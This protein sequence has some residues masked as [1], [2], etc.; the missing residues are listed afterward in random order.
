M[1]IG[2]IWDTYDLL[3]NAAFYAGKD[4]GYYDLLRPPVMSILTSFYF[5]DGLSVWPI[6]FIDGV[7]FVLGS[8]GLYLFFRLSFDDLTS[9]LGALLFVTFPIVLTFATAGLTDLSS[10]C[11]SIWGLLFTVLAV[12]KNTRFFYLAF[13]VLMLAFL[14]RFSSALLIFPLLLYILINK[15][16]IKPKKDLLIG[17]LVSILIIIPVFLFYYVNSGNPLYILLDFFRTSSVSVG[18]SSSIAFSYQ[19]DLLYYVNMVFYSAFHELIFVI[20]IINLGVIIFLFRHLTAKREFKGYNDNLIKTFL[21]LS[22]NNGKIKLIITLIFMVIFLFSLQ[23]V[24]YLVSEIL[25]FSFLLCAYNLLKIYKSRNLDIDFLFLS[26]FMAF[27]I[28]HSVYVIKDSRYFIE[29]APPLAYFIARG[30]KLATSQFNFQ[31]KNRNIFHIVFS[32]VLI[33]LT[34]VSAFTYLPTISETNA[35][36]KVMNENSVTMSSWLENYDPNYKEK[37]IYSDYWPYTAWNLQMNVNKMPIFRDGQVLYTGAKDYNFT[38]QDIIK[39]NQVLDDNKADY[40]FSRVGS[41]NLTNYRS[42]KQIGDFILYER[43]K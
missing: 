23:K 5:H 33:L 34:L 15:E 36:L 14:T 42:I 26:W 39:Y 2:P 12:K 31:I 25:F 30:F 29:M 9:F 35:H 11:I 28:F 8:I 37:V 20:L 6:M 38:E 17:I 13:P 22:E 40:Y 4:I 18:N 27:F 7:I 21:G 24:H 19:P 16:N 10:V 32:V 43:V 41:L 3:A 1:D